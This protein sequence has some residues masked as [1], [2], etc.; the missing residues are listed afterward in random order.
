MHLQLIRQ[1]QKRPGAVEIQSFSVLAA[2]EAIVATLNS[3]VHL[4]LDEFTLLMVQAEQAIPIYSTIC[5]TRSYLKLDSY[6]C[7]FKW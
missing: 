2:Y 7:C 4:Q 3:T 1:A 5:F 6:C